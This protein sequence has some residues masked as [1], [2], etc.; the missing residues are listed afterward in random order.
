VGTT[1]LVTDAHAAGL[2][3]VPYTFRA[4]NSFLPLQYRRGADP[5]AFGDLISYLKVAYATGVDGVF[6]DQPD[7]AYEA[8]AE[9]FPAGAGEP[10]DRGLART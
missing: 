10:P 6:V 1:T 7:I 2:R 8:R 5:A 9:M 3:V 4:E